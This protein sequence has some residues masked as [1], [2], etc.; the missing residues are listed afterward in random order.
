MKRGKA[1]E[2]VRQVW[3]GGN[4]PPLGVYVPHFPALFRF[5]RHPNQESA[6]SALE[7]NHSY[8]PKKRPDI[9][10]RDLDALA[11]ALEAPDKV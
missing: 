7:H 5:L 3:D 2:I 1:V 10:Q 8:T 4:N 6:I 9:W 11:K